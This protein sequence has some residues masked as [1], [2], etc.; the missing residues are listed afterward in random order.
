MTSVLPGAREALA[1]ARAAGSRVVVISAKFEPAV[2][3][4]LDEIGLAVDEVF[5]GVHGPEKASVLAGL[6]AAVYVGDTPAD[7]AAAVRAGAWP[8]GVATGSFAAADLA[9]AGA[10]VVLASLAEFPDWFAQLPYRDQ[11]AT[12]SATS[13]G[14][15]RL[16]PPG[17]ATVLAPRGTGVTRRWRM[18]EESGAATARTTGAAA[19]R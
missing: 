11:S 5:G 9:A 18:D 13:R 17:V 2:R 6:A 14:C 4:V 12:L 1:A 7:M 8:V 16:A 19:G 10:A 15:A 3:Q